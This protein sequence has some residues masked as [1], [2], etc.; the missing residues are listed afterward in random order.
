MSRLSEFVER[1]KVKYFLTNVD[2]SRDSVSADSRFEIFGCSVAIRFW[3][4]PTLEQTHLFA[5]LSLEN[6]QDKTLDEILSQ[7]AAQDIIEVVGQGRA[8]LVAKKI[9]PNGV[10]LFFFWHDDSTK[11]GGKIPELFLEENVI[12]YKLVRP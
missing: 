6:L 4:D 3:F 8:F 1:L 7:Q 9:V 11:E 10:L 5:N 12:E 2:C